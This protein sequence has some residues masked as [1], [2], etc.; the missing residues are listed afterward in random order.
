MSDYL[1]RRI[2][3][4]DN[5]DVA[6]IIRT[7][8]TEFGAVGKG[9]SIEDPEV[10]AMFEAYQVPGAAF[11]VIDRSNRVVGCGGI[12]PLVGGDPET[13]ELKKMYYLPEVRGQGLGRK[14][15][16]RLFVDA[17]RLG[18]K[19][20]YLETLARME[21]ANRLYAKLGFRPVPQNL[22]NT[23]HCRCDLYYVKELEEV[24]SEVT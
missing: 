11:Y 2:R 10:D 16:E 18:Y 4:E 1:L 14:L 19:R 22:G 8:M 21:S 17:A 23:G 5:A 24:R 9:Y 20:V 12:G 13:C 15:V 7:V 3:S 6:R